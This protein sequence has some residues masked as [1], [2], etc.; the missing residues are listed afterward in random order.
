MHEATRRFALL[1]V[2]LAAA[3][4]GPGSAASAECTVSK[5]SFHIQRL[6]GRVYSGNKL[7]V[8]I[9]PADGAQ[10]ASVAIVVDNRLALTVPAAQLEPRAD[11]WFGLVK[12]YQVGEPRAGAVRLGVD[13][14][15]SIRIEATDTTGRCVRTDGQT[16]WQTGSTDTFAVIVGINDYPNANS[17][18]SYA[19]QD[20]EAMARYARKYFNVS[21]PTRLFLLTDPWAATAEEPTDDLAEYRNDATRDN[22]LDA[23]SDVHDHIDAH[24]KLIFYFAGHGFTST[25]QQTFSSVYYLLARDS[26]LQRDTR[27]IAFQDIA[28]RLARSGANKAILIFDACF[29]D[30]FV[31]GF[32]TPSTVYGRA[33]SGTIRNPSIDSYASPNV[34]LMTA[35]TDDD[36][37][38]EPPALKHGVFTLQL[39]DAYKSLQ[40]GGGKKVTMYQ[41]FSYARDRV[42]LLLLEHMPGKQ[43]R[44]NH[45]LIGGADQIVWWEQVA[46]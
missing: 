16:I 23:L 7:D 25:D 45:N 46:P 40:A 19:R 9:M 11:G 14:S 22:I 33:L 4:F 43:Q 38:Y 20:A 30:R 26:Y 5:P 37:A 35:G 24:G 6:G 2:L 31:A 28:G 21:S 1:L 39:L 10:L 3:A 36:L 8:S 29:S 44:P 34:Y 17:N 13:V 18:L 41:A 12:E 15:G 27:M 42:P 32:S